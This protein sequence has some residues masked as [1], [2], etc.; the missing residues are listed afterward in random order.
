M[1]LVL[2]PGASSPAACSTNTATRSRARRWKCCS[3]ATRAAGAGLVRQSAIRK[4]HRR[5]RLVSGYSG[6]GRASTSSA[7][8]SA[9]PSAVADLPGYVRTLFPGTA[10]PREAQFVTIGAVAE[11]TGFDFGIVRAP[12]ATVSGR[13]VNTKDEPGAAAW[14]CC[15]ASTR[16]RF[17]AASG[18]RTN[19]SRRPF[20]VSERHARRVRHPSISGSHQ[21]VDRGRV[22]R[23]PRHRDGR[24]VAGVIVRTS[25][26]SSIRGRIVFEPAM[27]SNVPEPVGRRPVADPGGLR[28]VAAE[29]LRV[30]RTSGR[31]VRSP[32]RASTDRAGSRWSSAARA[33]C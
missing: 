6:C 30:R 32:S 19:L 33:G 21:R 4:R 27:G 31:T 24:D 17:W 14:S 26:G 25:A 2:E 3:C 18:G 1:S 9:A 16:C 22:R 11:V 8:R 10:L 23:G 7:P 13:F 28:P 29:Q 12:T 15:P 20:R 5:P